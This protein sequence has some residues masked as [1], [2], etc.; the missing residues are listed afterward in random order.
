MF[1]YALVN[2]VVFVV[3]T[4]HYPKHQVPVWLELRGFSGHWMMFYCVALAG[5]I[6]RRR[7]SRDA[8]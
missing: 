4:T 8:L 3:M 5:F 2:F 7:L 1:A 6:G